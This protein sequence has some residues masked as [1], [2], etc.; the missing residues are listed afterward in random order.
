[1]VNKPGVG[2]GML[3]SVA[4]APAFVAVVVNVWPPS[5]P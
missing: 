2:L 3:I 1:M 5:A 4:P